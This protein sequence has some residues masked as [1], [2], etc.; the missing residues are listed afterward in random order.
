MWRPK[1]RSGHLSHELYRVLH[2]D[3]E[4]DRTQW[5]VLYFQLRGRGF[6]TVVARSPRQLPA[7]S[8]SGRPFTCSRGE[9]ADNWRAFDGGNRQET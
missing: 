8:A 6:I 2:S 3:G 7:T 5:P 1:L 9:E 4:L